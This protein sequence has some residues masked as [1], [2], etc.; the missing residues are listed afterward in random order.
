MKLYLEIDM[1]SQIPN[2]WEIF[3]SLEF[4]YVESTIQIERAI[5]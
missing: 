4:N 5:R 3:K 2:Q 1:E